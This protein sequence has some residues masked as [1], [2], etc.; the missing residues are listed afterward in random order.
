MSDLET[1]L[2]SMG[3]TALAA[4]VADLSM[5]ADTSDD[6]NTVR[7]VMRLA[8]IVRRELVNNV[9]ETEAAGLIAEFSS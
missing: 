2:E 3:P 9:G 8:E 6:I 7:R 4:V 1:L 5:V